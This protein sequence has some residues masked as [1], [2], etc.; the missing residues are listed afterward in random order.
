MLKRSSQAKR[1]TVLVAL[2][3]TVAGSSACGSRNA[4]RAKNSAQLEFTGYVVDQ[5]RFLSHDARQRL[6]ERLGRFQRETG[7]Q[8]VVVTVST[9][10]GEEIKA[11]TIR[12]AN[13]WGVGRKGVNDGVVILIA[14]TERQERIS[15]GDGLRPQL[16][17]SYCQYVLDRVMVPAF[18]RGKFDQGVEAG[19]SALLTRAE[20]PYGS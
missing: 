10:E 8:L 6:T 12:L 9:L 2:A 13:R 20:A 4:S 5:A 19:V 18:A 1:L 17:D 14:P 15:V 16:P 11:F 7:H 3:W